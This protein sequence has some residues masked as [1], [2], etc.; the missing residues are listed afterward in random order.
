MPTGNENDQWQLTQEDEIRRDEAMPDPFGW[1]VFDFA[2][3]DVELRRDGFDP[4]SREV[5]VG[6]AWEGGGF[7]TFRIADA[8]GNWRFFEIDEGGYGFDDDE[9]RDSRR[10]RFFDSVEELLDLQGLCPQILNLSV[11]TLHDEYRSSLLRYAAEMLELV[12][13]NDISKF[14]KL[15]KLTAEDWIDPPWRLA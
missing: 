11:V 12:T 6:F 3:L 2:T 4:A 8:S 5:A 15:G 9:F 7:E 14:K 13:D 10:S 1:V